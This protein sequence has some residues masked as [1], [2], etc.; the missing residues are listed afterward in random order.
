MIGFGL[1]ATLLLIPLLAGLLFARDPERVRRTRAAIR[2][3]LTSGAETLIERFGRAGG[4]TIWLGGWIVGLMLVT[5]LVGIAVLVFATEASTP[6]D[7]SVTNLFLLGRTPALSTIWGTI[8]FLG[9]TSFLVPVA[10]VLGLLWRWRKGDWLVL[11]VLLGSYLGAS[12]LFNVTKRLVNRARPAAEIAFNAETGMSFP[13][14]HT[15]DTAAFYTAGALLL[16]TLVASWALRA[17]IGAASASLIMLVATSRIYL[18]A[19]WFTDV[20]CGA[21]LG[22]AWAAVLWTALTCRGGPFPR[23]RQVERAAAHTGSPR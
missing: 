13:S 2:G 3:P 12:V 23:E 21:V 10:L 8:T 19:H 20:I 4:L 18:G 14:G 16:A 17:A 7:E 9:D 22:V 15:T 6:L 11:A 5:W 1:M